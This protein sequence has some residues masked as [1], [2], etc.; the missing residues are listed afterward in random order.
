MT[1]WFFLAK[2]FAFSKF[3]DRFIISLNIDFQII[4]L[5]FLGIDTSHFTRVEHVCTDSLS[6]YA[7]ELTTK[8]VVN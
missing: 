7:T 2:R 5:I 1:Y 8:T 3:Y 6:N 4:P